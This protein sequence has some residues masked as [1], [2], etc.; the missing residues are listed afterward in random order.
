MIERLDAG[1]LYLE[2]FTRARPAGAARVKIQ[3]PAQ[4]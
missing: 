4:P 1:E 2:V 3:V